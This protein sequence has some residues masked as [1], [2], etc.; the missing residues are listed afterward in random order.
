[1]SRPLPKTGPGRILRQIWKDRI[2]YLFL[3]PF[4]LSFILFTVL[5]VLT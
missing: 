4:A 3:L 5:P 1:M 2:S